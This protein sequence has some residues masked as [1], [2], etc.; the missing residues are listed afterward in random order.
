[1]PG[2]GS[3][4]RRMD[5]RGAPTA[6][7]QGS[8]RSHRASGKGIKWS[9]QSVDTSNISAHWPLKRWRKRIVK[10]LLYG[11]FFGAAGMYLYMTQGALLDSSITA[12]LQWRDASK[13]SVH[14]YGGN[15]G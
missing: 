9:C 4:N 10:T 7:N 8:R 12:L 5:E 2:H 3:L 15:R 11:I 6:C 13:Q 14:G 1:M